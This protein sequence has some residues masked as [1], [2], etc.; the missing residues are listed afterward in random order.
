MTTAL[1]VVAIGASALTLIAFIFDGVFDA[2][3]LS[4]PG[5]VGI[6]TVGIVGGIAVFGWTG[7]ILQQL[8]D[9]PAAAVIGV[10]VVAGLVMMLL[11][12]ALA[13]AL[14]RRSANQPQDTDLTGQTGM[15]TTA[16]SP[17]RPG[18][19]RIRWQGAPRTL[20]ALAEQD[21]PEGAMVRI[22]RADGTERALVA[23]VD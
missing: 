23:P 20:T 10:A 9:W 16:A 5:D 3:E 1:L 18:V 11:L 22:V 13:K 17:Q 6:S 7:L 8:T 14:H 2:F 19:V 4:L 15:L 21:L 12:G